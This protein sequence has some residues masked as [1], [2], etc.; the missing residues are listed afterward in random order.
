MP[1]RVRVWVQGRAD[2]GNLNLQWHDPL[3]GGRKS[4]TA[5]TA[6]RREAE[7]RA[8]DLEYEL[9][10]GLYREDSGVTWPDFRARFEAE[11]AAGLRDA[12]REKYRAVLD[13]FEAI[14]NPRLLKAVNERAVSAFVTGLRS[15][16]LP[17]GKVG[18][19]PATVKNYVVTLGVAL[20][21]AV[22]QKFLAA[23]P[24]FP[25]VKVPKKRPQPVPAESF[26]R[27]LAVAPDDRWRAFLLCG[28][29]AGLR[30]SEALRLRW[31]PQDRYP[32]VDFARRR[33]VLPAAFV[34]ATEDQWVPMHAVLRDA[35]AALP[36]TGPEVF[37]FR[38]RKTGGPLSR[39]GAS[40]A[41]IRLA[42]KA[43]VRLSMHRLRRGFGSRVARQFGRAGSA[44][45]HQLL[46]HASLQTTLDYY[47]DVGDA[48]Y[49]AIDALE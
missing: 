31:E 5:G 1:E 12:T 43:G 25:A 33:V 18:C 14:V 37:G 46:R 3:T 15:R 11:H 29:W 17:G 23:V 28:W 2:R 16:P 8:A 13:A 40:N 32:W 48:L 7:R 27:L 41:V 44:M 30:L 4:R 24:T 20:R 21:W 10:R 26:E 38:S 42:R 9:S 34:K 47:A 22:G 39:H 19:A 36:R 45:A 49:D 6:D 35:L